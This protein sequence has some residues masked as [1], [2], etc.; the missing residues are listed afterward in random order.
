MPR[1][2]RP[3]YPV[4]YGQPHHWA[5]L[6]DWRDMNSLT[7]ENVAETLRTTGATV[8]RWEKGTAAVTGPQYVALAKLYGASDVGM[9]SLPPPRRSDIA[10]VREA[11]RIVA[12][13][14]D[15]AQ[16]ADWLA[17]GRVL[18]TIAA[19]GKKSRDT[20]E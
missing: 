5:Y 15:E 6:G 18:A 17:Q 8:S 13:L 16:R 1:K 14:Q 4:P 12:E 3:S 20:Q 2:R 7:Q 11:F 9:L 19:A 10:A